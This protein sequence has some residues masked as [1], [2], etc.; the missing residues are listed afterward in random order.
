VT[1]QA[2]SWAW[3]DSWRWKEIDMF[4][5]ASTLAVGPKEPPVQWMLE[6]LT[7]E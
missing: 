1:D 4:S 7:L 6:A 2:T 3:F 5:S